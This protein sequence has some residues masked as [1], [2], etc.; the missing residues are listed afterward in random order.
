MTTPAFYNLDRMQF[1]PATG[2]FLAEETPQGAE[3]W[4]ANRNTP[5]AAAIVA[6]MTE[7][8][9]ILTEANARHTAQQAVN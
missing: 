9:A 7:A 1:D 4:A 5:E 3:W 2:A 6:F 8:S